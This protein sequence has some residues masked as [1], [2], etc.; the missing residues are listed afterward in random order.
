[1]SIRLST[2]SLCSII[3]I[4]LMTPGVAEPQEFILTTQKIDGNL[5]LPDLRTCASKREEL[6]FVVN[7]ESQALIY[8]HPYKMLYTL[9]FA[10]S[11]SVGHRAVTYTFDSDNDIFFFAIQRQN[12]VVAVSVTPNSLRNKT[13]QPIFNQPTH[14]DD[15]RAMMLEFIGSNL[16]FRTS[17]CSYYYISVFEV[18]LTASDTFRLA[19]LPIEESLT[20]DCISGNTSHVSLSNKRILVL[21]VPN[22]ALISY[23][24]EP[25]KKLQTLSIVGKLVYTMDLSKLDEK[26]LSQDDQPGHSSQHIKKCQYGFHIM[27]DPNSQ[28]LLL[29]CLRDR[30]HYI[31][32]LDP[33]ILIGS[34]IDVEP[35][36]YGFFAS[37]THY[38]D[39]HVPISSVIFGFE[40]NGHFLLRQFT[41]IGEVPKFNV[42]DFH[43]V[44]SHRVFNVFVDEASNSLLMATLNGTVLSIDDAALPDHFLVNKQNFTL[45]NGSLCNENKFCL[46]TEQKRED[47]LS[48]RLN[49]SIFETIIRYGCSQQK[50]EKGFEKNCLTAP[51]TQEDDHELPSDDS[52]LQSVCMDNSLRVLDIESKSLGYLPIA[53]KDLFSHC[54]RNPKECLVTNSLI[55][56]HLALVCYAQ[57]GAIFYGAYQV[58]LPITFLVHNNP[59]NVSSSKF[60]IGK[61]ENEAKYHGSVYYGLPFAANML[62]TF[63]YAHVG[64]SPRVT[65]MLFR[66]EERFQLQNQFTLTGFDPLSLRK[67]LSTN[68]SFDYVLFTFEDIYYLEFNIYYFVAKDYHRFRYDLQC[69]SCLASRYK[70]RLDFLNRV[71]TLNFFSYSESSGCQAPYPPSDNSSVSELQ[72]CFKVPDFRLCHYIHDDKS[73]QIKVFPHQNYSTCKLE[74]N[75]STTWL[76]VEFRL[77]E[78]EQLIFKFDITNQTFAY[79]NMRPVEQII[80]KTN[81]S[82]ENEFQNFSVYITM[83]KPYELLLK[84]S[85]RH[86]KLVLIYKDFSEPILQV[87]FIVLKIS[88]ICLVAARCS[89]LAVRRRWNDPM[90]WDIDFDTEPENPYQLIGYEANFHGTELALTPE[91]RETLENRGFFIEYEGNPVPTAGNDCVLCLEGVEERPYQIYLCGRHYVHQDCFGVWIQKS[92]EQNKTDLC[93]FRCSTILFKEPEHEPGIETTALTNSESMSSSVPLEDAIREENAQNNEC[94]LKVKKRKK[95]KKVAAES[96][97]IQLAETNFKQSESN[98]GPRANEAIISIVQDSSDIQ[99]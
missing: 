28:I 38:S 6:A 36:V 9:D 77:E 78:N 34:A 53:K 42:T 88:L 40:Q 21:D 15:S 5:S 16:I 14:Y 83:N 74:L 76:F 2:L 27:Q 39:P 30:R 65:L 71:D 7:C 24:I 82:E 22:K 97:T 4:L 46:S 58:D 48:L 44:K 23:Q 75:L 92:I 87:V 56:M 66:F 51:P 98:E 11:S 17:Q 43:F 68:S 95:K 41:K 90:L 62:I 3:L 19:R 8:I 84:D 86:A 49:E 79:A 80:F 99:E 81:T 72:D 64:P 1:M 55:I 25:S 63:D 60:I 13:F 73:Q 69:T 20:N 45:E 47:L 10:N 32:N 50:I 93:P 31:F 52:I 67:T 85:D 70:E 89:I 37:N 35:V 29:S 26:L 33:L 94:S 57:G 96:R 59:T 54:S 61:Y 91:M 12:F 18:L